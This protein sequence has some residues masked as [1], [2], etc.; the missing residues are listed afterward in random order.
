MPNEKPEPQRIEARKV[1]AELSSVLRRVLAGERFIITKRGRDAVELIPIPG[2]HTDI[3]RARQLERGHEIDLMQALQARGFSVCRQVRIGHKR[4][5]LVLYDPDGSVMA[6]IEVKCR[7]GLPASKAAA[8]AQ[9][10]WYARESGARKCLVFCPKMDDRFH[11][12]DSGVLFCSTA[13]AVMVHLEMSVVS[14]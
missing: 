9:A 11:G 12:F 3:K 7:I 8:F 1:R 13:D 5:D 4:A 10:A 6:I 2:V 14:A